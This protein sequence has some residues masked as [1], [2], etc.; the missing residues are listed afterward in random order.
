MELHAE[1]R[2]VLG[3]RDDAF[4]RRGRGGSLGRVGVR[5]P[6][7]LAGRLDGRPTDA[8]H[9]LGAQAH[10][11]PGNEAEA[12]DAAVLLGLVERELEAEADAECGAAGSG[13]LEQ[14]LVE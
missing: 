13:A 5:E 11:T 14:R 10:R 1:E 6:E 3:D 4:A 7:G 2:P 8:G 12:G 9:A